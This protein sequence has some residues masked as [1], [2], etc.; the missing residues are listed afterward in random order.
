MS[1]N[2]PARALATPLYRKR[3]VSNAKKKRTE[4]V[5]DVCGGDG[6]AYDCDI[7]EANTCYACGG[8]GFIL[9]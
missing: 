5:C 1:R 8:L 9:E 4:C 6:Q 2:Q 3:V 7:D